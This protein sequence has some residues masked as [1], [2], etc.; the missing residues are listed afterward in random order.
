MK[1]GF[2]LIDWTTI[3]T[4]RAFLRSEEVGICNELLYEESDIVEKAKQQT[5][6]TLEI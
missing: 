1:M 4:T 2:R 5:L 3:F 6:S